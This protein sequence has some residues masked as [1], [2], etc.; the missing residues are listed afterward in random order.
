MA[1]MIPHNVERFATDGEKAFYAFLEKV[2]KPDAQ[3]LAWYT[4]DIEGRE[5]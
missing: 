4:P 1:T 3:Y 2:A 5:P